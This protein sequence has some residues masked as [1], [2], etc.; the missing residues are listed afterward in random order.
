M[1]GQIT[2]QYAVAYMNTMTW[3]LSGRFQEFWIKPES[4]LSADAELVYTATSNMDLD[5]QIFSIT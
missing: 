3:L 5:H 2:M 4:V 1:L